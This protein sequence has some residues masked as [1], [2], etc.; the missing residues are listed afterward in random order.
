[1]L[2]VK[3]EDSLPVVPKMSSFDNQTSFWGAKAI[4]THCV[5]DDLC[6][7]NLEEMYPWLMWCFLIWQDRK[8][9]K[10]MLL[11]SSSSELPGKMSWPVVL[12]LVQIKLFSIPII[13]C[14]LIFFFDFTGC[15]LRILDAELLALKGTGLCGKWKST[16]LCWDPAPPRLVHDWGTSSLPDLCKNYVL[17][18]ILLPFKHCEHLSIQ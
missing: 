8:L 7:W 18:I 13:D 9:L 3:T 1:M 10:I 5:H 6:F 14:L 17:N 11:Q 4:L 2:K 12:G 15:F 16:Q